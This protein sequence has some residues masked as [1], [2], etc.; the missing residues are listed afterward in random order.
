MFGFHSKKGSK[1][2][3]GKKTSAGKKPKPKMRAKFNKSAKPRATIPKDLKIG[4]SF[5]YGG[6]KIRVIDQKTAHMIIN[7][8]KGEYG[9]NP[10]GRFIVPYSDGKYEAIDNS[11]G[12]AYVE[13]FDTDYTSAVKW[14]AG[15]I[16]IDDYLEKKEKAKAKRK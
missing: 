5:E 2:K 13:D 8:G 7:S 1:P 11:F 3:G 10:E 12:S 6:E 14:L 4:S 9:Y 16:E 15:K